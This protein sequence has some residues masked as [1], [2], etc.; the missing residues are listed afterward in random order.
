ML[1]EI[2]AQ[3]WQL[4]SCVSVRILGCNDL[5][6]T[7]GY[8]SETDPY[9]IVAL[10]GNEIGR[11]PVCH[12]TLQP[13]WEACEYPLYL[14]RSED[15]SAALS[16]LSDVA[17]DM[18]RCADFDEAETKSSSQCEC[19]GDALS[20]I[21]KT[22]S[23]SNLKRVVMLAEKIERARHNY[24]TNSVTFSS[25]SRFFFVARIGHEAVQTRLDFPLT[26]DDATDL[27]PLDA[28]GLVSIALHISSATGMRQQSTLQE[29]MQC[30]D[31]VNYTLQQA[32]LELEVWAEGKESVQCVLSGC[33]SIPLLDSSLKSFTKVEMQADGGGAILQPAVSDENV[34][35]LSIA[36]AVEIGLC[37]ANGTAAAVAPPAAAQ[38]GGAVN[39][40]RTL[41]RVPPRPPPAFLVYFAQCTVR[42]TAL[43]HHQR[44]PIDA[45]LRMTL[46]GKHRRL[47]KFESR[48]SIATLPDILVMSAR[49]SIE[50]Y[51]SIGIEIFED[52]VPDGDAVLV[53]GS[54]PFKPTLGAWEYH[55]CA[56]TDEC[57]EEK[58]SLSFYMLAITPGESIPP[59]PLNWNAIEA[60]EAGA[61]DSLTTTTMSATPT[62]KCNMESLYG[63]LKIKVYNIAIIDMPQTACDR[64]SGG[65]Q[66]SFYCVVRLGAISG[67]TSVCDGDVETC[68][69]TGESLELC[70][71]VHDHDIGNG[72]AVCAE[73]SRWS[74]EYLVI[75]VWNDNKQGVGTLVGRARTFLAHHLSHLGREWTFNGDLILPQKGGDCRQGS[76]HCNLVINASLH[77]SIPSVKSSDKGNTVFQ[78][79]PNEL[80]VSLIQARNLRPMKGNLAGALTPPDTFVTL[81]CSG[82]FENSCV[83]RESLCPV[84]NEAFLFEVM[85]QNCPNLSLDAVVKTSN[86]SRLIEPIGHVSIPL[87]DLIDGR[88]LRRWYTLQHEPV[89]LDSCNLKIPSY[90]D[91]QFG[92]LELATMWYY[93]PSLDYLMELIESKEH[94]ILPPNELLV[95]VIQGQDL[96][97][98][99]RD[100]FSRAELFVRLEVDGEERETDVKHGAR[101]PVWHQKFR[102]P[103]ADSDNAV[104]NLTVLN[105]NMAG[106]AKFM[107]RGNLQLSLLRNRKCQRLWIHLAGADGVPGK[108]DVELAL[109][110]VHNPKLALFDDL[111][112]RNGDEYPGMTQN[113]LRLAVVRA[114]QLPATDLGR[115]SNAYV[116]VCILSTER[117]D[118]SDAGRLISSCR[119]HTSSP[120]LKNRAGSHNVVESEI[121]KN[122]NG[123][124]VAAPK[125]SVLSHVETKKKRQAL[126]PKWY[127]SFTLECN[128]PQELG[129]KR[130][131]TWPKLLLEV[132]DESDGALELVGSAVI[133]LAHHLDRKRRRFWTNLEPSER[134]A[135][136]SRGQLEVVLQYDPVSNMKQMNFL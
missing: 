55:S 44:S 64:S 37:V 12:N 56:L 111:V 60:H 28:T 35:E 95:V 133:E 68:R 4:E 3:K 76:F 108:G 131:H 105:W 119:I 65:K 136:E 11:T 73:S 127:E 63:V 112:G 25:P 110:W 98:V 45:W 20:L 48:K 134:Y 117:E 78:A 132:L 90:T 6:R 120:S 30:I 87:V 77:Q 15:G 93:N 52:G 19:Q 100:V 129:N 116:R 40:L 42:H 16:T 57:P 69:W 114:K 97:T 66:Q 96:G 58:G 80:K 75:E 118:K 103:A 79:E 41:N 123:N 89:T 70:A 31:D 24:P 92:E 62:K 50:A 135:V 128:A 18:F 86:D 2:K 5:S 32:E 109:R 10:N 61:A 53:R 130:S 115:V 47:K 23:W 7:H 1:K 14:N 88:H 83:R 67:S 17:Q 124:K 82:N 102:I 84:W 91:C 72:V 94:A 51:E 99:D 113:C 104:L 101:H 33:S 122:T 126:A 13:R 125:A 26:K 59:T 49:Y 46:G 54:L 22:T 36:V 107:G 81:S 9:V 27:Q 121:S 74:D 34:F 8:G 29:K 39:T 71:S 43:F 85:P 106:T 21:I 38:A